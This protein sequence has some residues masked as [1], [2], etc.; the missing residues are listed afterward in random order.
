MLAMRQHKDVVIK[1]ISASEVSGLVPDWYR[2]RIVAD[3]YV[4]L[5]PLVVDQKALGL[6]YIDGDAASTRLLTPALLNYLKVL[7]GQAIVAIRQKS[8]RPDPRRK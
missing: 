8:A 7:R 1:D 6:F 4:V 3:R 5:L 2:Q